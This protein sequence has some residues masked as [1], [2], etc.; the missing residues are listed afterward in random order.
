MKRVRGPRMKR[1]RGPRMKRVR[2]PRMKRVRGHR[3]QSVRGPRLPGLRG[4]GGAQMC[5]RAGGNAPREID[6]GTGTSTRYQRVSLKHG[7]HPTTV[8]QHKHQLK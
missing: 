4:R 2:G 8:Y 3:L 1:V 6:H 5:I 7:P